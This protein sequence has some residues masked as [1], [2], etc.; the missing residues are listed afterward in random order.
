M[1]VLKNYKLLKERFNEFQ[2][3]QIRYD[4]EVFVDLPICTIEFGQLL[5]HP[6]LFV[7]GAKTP[8]AVELSWL[9]DFLSNKKKFNLFIDEKGKI[10]EVE[11]GE[12]NY[13]ILLPNDTDLSELWFE[14]GNLVRTRKGDPD[15]N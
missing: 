15:V 4:D 10:I 11:P 9:Q 5:E 13:Q 7:N 12:S 8:S 1:R 2:F 6:V 3:I 14:N